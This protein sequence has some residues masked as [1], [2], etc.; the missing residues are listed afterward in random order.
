MPQVHVDSRKLRSFSR[1]LTDFASVVE[2][3]MSGLK[4]SL[5]RLGETWRDQEFEAFINQL[6]LA[7]H[8]LSQFVEEAKRTA[9]L[10]ERDA[11]A[12]DDLNRLKPP[13]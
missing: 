4:N 5:G 6:S 12:I 3:Q 7:Q 10:L 9:P 2:D 1:E 8:H 11:T 13:M